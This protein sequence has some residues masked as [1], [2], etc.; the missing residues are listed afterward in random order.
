M[1]LDARLT[2]TEWCWR[3][4]WVGP[5]AYVAGL[6]PPQ[7]AASRTAAG[8]TTLLRT[9]QLL[10]QACGAHRSWIRL[11][12]RGGLLQPGSF[13]R[14]QADDRRVQL[15]V[16]ELVGRQP[17]AEA[18]LGDPLRVVVLIPEEREDDQRHAE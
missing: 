18:A 16:L 1:S 3:H 15:L 12:P 4:V 5:T 17:H 14:E 10:D 8:A 9:R 13:A 2:W 11:Q 7:P 6:P